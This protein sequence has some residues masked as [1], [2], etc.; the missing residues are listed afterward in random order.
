LLISTIT[1]SE[2]IRTTAAIKKAQ[3]AEGATEHE[4]TYGPSRKMNFNC[5][6]ERKTIF[7]T[8]KKVIIIIQFNSIGLFLHANSKAP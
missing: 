6:E 2:R 4:V 3:V 8:S 5:F 1:D 7:S